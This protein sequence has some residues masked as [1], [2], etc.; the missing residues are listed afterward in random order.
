MPRYA[1]FL[2]AVNVG[3]TGKLPMADLKAMCSDLGFKDMKT[4]I[5]SG[6]VVFNSVLHGE[7]VQ[8]QLTKVLSV[9]LDKPVAVAIRTRDELLEL[10]SKSPFPNVEENKHI[11]IL[12]DETPPADIA[13]SAKHHTDE[14]I[15]VRDR[16]LHVYYP[17]GMGISKLKIPGTEKGTSRNMNT[18][19]KMV[20]LMVNE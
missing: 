17:S 15:T 9:Y 13:F 18:I 3:G 16:V 7:Q 14:L 11:L 5:A 2:R 6:N 1:A 12:L 19:R 20:E 4:Y 10:V 8:A